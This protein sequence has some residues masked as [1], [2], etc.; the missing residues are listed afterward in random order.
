MTAQQVN[1]DARPR[2]AA[3]RPDWLPIIRVGAE[4]L[5]AHDRALGR[6]G[7][8]LPGSRLGLLRDDGRLPRRTGEPAAATAAAIAPTADAHGAYAPPMDPLDVL[9]RGAAGFAT[10]LD[11]VAHDQWDAPSGLGDWTV[12][13]LARP[14]DRR[15]PHVDGDPRRG[16]PQRRARRV[17]AVGRGRGPRRGLRRGQ[18][19]HGGRLR[20]SRARSTARSRIPRWTCRAASSSASGSASTRSTAGTSLVPS[21]PTTRST[22][23]SSQAL[24]ALMEPLAPFLPGDRDVRRRPQRHGARRRA[25]AA[26]RARPVRPPPLTYGCWGL[27]PGSLRVA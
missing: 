15:R 16:N 18:Q 4:I 24:W 1:G 8:G 13:Q 25:A 22:P 26:P 21:V 17:R 10:T 27:P 3:I 20:R 19:R 11:Q 9:A 7:A 5:A 14:R 2:R 23:T 6:G 12:R